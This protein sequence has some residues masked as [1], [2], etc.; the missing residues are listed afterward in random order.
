MDF[1][2]LSPSK[3]D[4]YDFAITTAAAYASTP[5]PSF[6][7]VAREGD[8]VLWER[9]GETPSD[10]GCSTR[11]AIQARYSTATRTRPGT[12]AAT[13]LHDTRDGRPGEHGSRGFFASAPGQRLGSCRRC[14][15]A[16]SRRRF[17][18][19]ARSPLTVSRGRRGDR[20]AAAVARGLLPHAAPAEARSGPRASWSP[21]GGPARDRDRG[22]GAERRSR[23]R[24]GSSAKS[25]S[26]QWRSR[27]DGQPD[28]E[29]SRA[30]CGEYVDH[31]FLELDP[32]EPTPR[33]SSSSA[34]PAAAARTSSPSSSATTR[35]LHAIPIECRFHANPK[36]LS[37]VVTG[38]ATPAA[39]L[40]KL[41][42]YWWHRVRVGERALVR[43]R[44]RARGEGKERGLHKIVDKDAFEAAAR[45]FEDATAGIE[46]G[47][48]PE[49]VAASRELFFDLL[50]PLRDG[51][52]GLV[53]MSCFTIASARGLERI[54]PEA[55]FVHS[56]RDGRDSGSSKVSKAQKSHHPSDAATGVEWWEGRLALAERGYR[57]L[58]RSRRSSTPSAS[59]SSSGATARPR[60]RA[61]A[62]FAG[63]GR[64]ARHASLLRRGDERRERPP[65]ALARGPRRGAA[66]RRSSSATSRRSSGSSARATT[67]RSSSA[68]T[69]SAQ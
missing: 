28:V 52:P 12:R 39:F 7:E 21:N 8:Y 60:T 32:N 57:G 31:F 56:V 1:D 44:W 9:T 35:A 16:C 64:R 26:V 34:A 5:P 65:R 47:T 20:R 59:T 58:S 62:T 68:E 49:V 11:A 30:R 63:L 23:M 13:V 37:E 45:R 53:E 46:D 3:L 42:R 36:G 2:T 27:A 66:S 50:G 48:R 22:R 41:R 43:A 38:A 61:L 69:T 24:S 10:H 25:G 67:A 18:T 19:T 6:E 40:T 14:P 17:S 51:K 55:L 4:N 29:S 33:P 15:P 54:F